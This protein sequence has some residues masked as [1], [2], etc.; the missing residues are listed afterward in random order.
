MLDKSG[1]VL[2][3]VRKSGLRLGLEAGRVIAPP[4]QQKWPVGDGFV[5]QPPSRLLSFVQAN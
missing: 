5:L 2:V 4:L 1:N 3:A